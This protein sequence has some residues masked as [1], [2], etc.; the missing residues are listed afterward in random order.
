MF[1]K[2]HKSKIKS[3]LAFTSSSAVK[4]QTFLTYHSFLNMGNTVCK[5]IG[6][7]L[8]PRNFV[9]HCCLFSPPKTIND[10]DDDELPLS[11]IRP[12]Y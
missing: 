2:R 7:Y 5:K 3:F 9:C 12:F 1:N 4:G 11:F 8:F 6:R 10:N